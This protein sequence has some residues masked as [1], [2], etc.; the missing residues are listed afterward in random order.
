[1]GD[2]AAKILRIEKD[3]LI[4]TGRNAAAAGFFG[5]WRS[6]NALELVNVAVGGV[7]PI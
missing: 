7:E 3:R 2:T 4:M 1:V 5:F 6:L